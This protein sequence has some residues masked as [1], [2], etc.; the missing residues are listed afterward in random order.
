MR[1][2]ER[3]DVWRESVDLVVEVYMI[4]A[5]FPK[6]EMYGLTAQ[7]RRATTSV[8]ANIAEGCARKGM[9]EEDQFFY[10][11]RGSLSELE[12]HLLV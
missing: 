12:T 8:P 11:A 7:M 9:K 3:L 1:P 5:S 6:E 10:I 2:H 4:T